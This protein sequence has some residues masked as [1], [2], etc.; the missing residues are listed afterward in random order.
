[1]VAKEA[2]PLSK[3]IPAGEPYTNRLGMKFRYCPPNNTGRSPENPNLGDQPSIGTNPTVGFF[4]SETE[5][6]QDQYE[7]VIGRNPSKFSASGPNAPVDSASI[8]EIIIFADTLS[9][10]EPGLRY[11]LPTEKEWI[12]A[13][14]ASQPVHGFT[15]TDALGWTET[16]SKG[17]THPCGQKQPNPW[18]LQ[19]MV[20]NVAEWCSSI[21][22]GGLFADAERRD[23]KTA[24]RLLGGSWRDTIATGTEATTPLVS[25]PQDETGFRLILEMDKS[26]LESFTGSVLSRIQKESSIVSDR[27]QQMEQKHQARLKTNERRLIEE[28]YVDDIESVAWSLIEQ[29]WLENDEANGRLSSIGRKELDKLKSTNL[30]RVKALRR[31]PQYLSFNIPADLGKTTK[32]YLQLEGHYMTGHGRGGSPD[33]AGWSGPLENRIKIGKRV[34]S[35][36]QRLTSSKP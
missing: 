15:V 29:C 16:N 22:T 24:M 11:R 31:N 28:K 21:P 20:G 9:K 36:I 33:T 1:M 2:G 7:T 12:H 34:I 17:T 23:Q 35:L 6:T 5:V 13:F 3:Q 4:I 14:L 25:R 30:S 32:A 27:E 18:G 19:D 10:R 8:A 26:V